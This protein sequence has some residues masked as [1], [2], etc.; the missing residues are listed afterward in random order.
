VQG[1]LSYWF[2]LKPLS[3]QSSK[4]N[5]GHPRSKASD[6][7]LVYICDVMG[8]FGPANCQQASEQHSIRQRARQMQPKENSFSSS[9]E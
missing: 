5:F 2:K 4:I 7:P 1:A 6:F 9:E 3:G 8:K